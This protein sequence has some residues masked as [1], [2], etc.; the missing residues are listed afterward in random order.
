MLTNAT[1]LRIDT[2]GAPDPAGKVTLTP[3]AAMACRCAVL[4]ARAGDKYRAEAQE[5]RADATL[6]VTLTAFNL[7][8]AL[9]G[10][11]ARFALLPEQWVVIAMDGDP[12]DTQT[13]YRVRSVDT[14]PGPGGLA[15]MRAE[16]MQD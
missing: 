12:T 13:S 3:G 8:L 1:L 2:P 16:L 5:E 15:S 4:P 10:Y 11:T 7:A 6:I 14:R 9:A